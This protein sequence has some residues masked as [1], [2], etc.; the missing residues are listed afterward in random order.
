[1]S[2]EVGEGISGDGNVMSYLTNMVTG[3]P[4]LWFTGKSPDCL[5][6]LEA[7]MIL[8]RMFPSSCPLGHW[9]CLVQKVRSQCFAYKGAS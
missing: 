4:R 5:S 6:G 7:L 1:M 2:Q 9:C 3:W 8:E